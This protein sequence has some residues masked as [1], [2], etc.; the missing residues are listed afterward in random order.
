MA[1]WRFIA[2]DFPEAQPLA[3]LTGVEQDLR[4]AEW[5]CDLFIEEREKSNEE[6][7]E[8]PPN[9]ALWEALTV[10]ASVRYARA[11][12]KGVRTNN[13]VDTAVSGLPAEMAID[14]HRYIDFRNKHI[15]HSVNAFE[16]N[17]VVGYLIP[18]ERGPRGVASI[19][20]QHE[21]LLSLS[22]EDVRRLKGLCVEM[23]SRIT[24]LIERRRPGS[25]RLHG[26]Y[27]SMICTLKW[28]RRRRFL[29]GAK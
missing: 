22:V 9:P 23:L 21:R 5:F 4:A 11:F 6:R 15:A 26:G 29:P 18:E 17:R 2:L 28:T 24:G 10:A 20:V 25:W 19:S 13:W 7:K 1:T 12:A 8:T 16:E 27:R 14:H 3:D